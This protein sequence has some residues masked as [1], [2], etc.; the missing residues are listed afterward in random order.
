MLYH[1]SIFVFTIMIKV[2]VALSCVWFSLLP[3]SF[4]LNL[5]IGQ[6][7]FGMIFE[8]SETNKWQKLANQDYVFFASSDFMVALHKD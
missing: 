5:V 1:I 4:S 3:Y 2:Y 8:A 7:T 6:D